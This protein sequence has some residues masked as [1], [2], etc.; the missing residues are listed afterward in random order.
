MP[1]RGQINFRLDERTDR[2]LSRL[3]RKLNINAAAVVRLALARLAD[4]EGG[5]DAEAKGKP[6]A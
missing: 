4:I 2:L 6:P 5:A 3:E 1:P